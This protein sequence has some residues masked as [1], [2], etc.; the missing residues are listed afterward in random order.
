MNNSS[1]YFSQLSSV[2]QNDRRFAGY[3]IWYI[4]PLYFIG[5]LEV[6]LLNFQLIWGRIGVLIYWHTPAHILKVR[7]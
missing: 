1:L 5:N 2:G 6:I 3:L 7:G 4:L